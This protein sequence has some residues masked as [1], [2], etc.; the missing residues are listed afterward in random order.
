MDREEPDYGED[1]GEDF[2]DDNAEEL[3]EN[4]NVDPAMGGRA[5]SPTQFLTGA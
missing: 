4:P 2:G 1:Y 3:N 5:R